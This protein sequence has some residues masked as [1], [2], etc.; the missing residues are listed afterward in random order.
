MSRLQGNKLFFHPKKLLLRPCNSLP[1]STY[2][3]RG[4]HCT[5]FY[6]TWRRLR[7]NSIC[8]SL[9][10]LQSL[11]NRL[12]NVTNRR[13][14]ADSSQQRKDFRPQKGHLSTVTIR[15]LNCSC[16]MCSIP[17]TFHSLNTTM[18]SH[19]RHRN[20]QPK[21]LDMLLFLHTFQ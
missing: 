8:W 2:S 21:E 16:S 9:R 4:R 12:C 7:F 19:L 20:L 6:S 11:R 14:R 10:C 5:H 17:F 15:E 1:N 3:G 18:K 13:K